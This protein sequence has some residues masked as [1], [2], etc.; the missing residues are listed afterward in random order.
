MT[1]PDKTAE[2][3]AID[4]EHKDRLEEI[5]LEIRRHT[6]SMLT[7]YWNVGKLADEIV[8]DQ[9]AEAKFGQG[10]LKYVAEKTGHHLSEIYRM[11]T[12][13]RR[14][15]EEQINKLSTMGV[16]ITHVVDAC[17]IVD[18]EKRMAA[19]SLWGTDASAEKMNHTDFKV[20][21]KGIAIG[22]AHV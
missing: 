1:T 9:N 21:V 20:V 17:S 2:V 12:V 19:L 11:H 10:A 16:Y 8:K 3:T 15:P 4:N 5:I 14:Y 6:G 22:R 13:F 18:D 7:E